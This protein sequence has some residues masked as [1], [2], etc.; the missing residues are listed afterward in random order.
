MSYV[1]CWYS[2]KRIEY[3]RERK[4]QK[5]KHWMSNVLRLSARHLP[6]YLICIKC[7]HSG[8]R[9]IVLD[10]MSSIFGLNSGHGGKRVDK[11]QLLSGYL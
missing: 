3:L 2:L 10:R 5:S 4:V 6:F 9:E 8:N 7:P 11:S 1:V